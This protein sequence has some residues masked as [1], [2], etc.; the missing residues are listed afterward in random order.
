MGDR[1]I[2]EA[3]AAADAREAHLVRMVL[4][5]A[6]I[7]ARVVGEAFQAVE[8]ELPSTFDVADGRLPRV[9][10]FESDADRART[11]LAEWKNRRR[12]DG[13]VSRASWECPQCGAE[14]DV[15]FDLCWKCQRPKGSP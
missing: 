2:V 14:V 15:D 13:T 3:Y 5:E 7:E 8:G 9:W 12:G 6:G 11:I 10:V 4:Q 1:R